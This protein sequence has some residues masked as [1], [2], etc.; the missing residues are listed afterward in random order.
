MKEKKLMLLNYVQRA[1]S[2][3]GLPVSLLKSTTVNGTD[4]SVNRIDRQLIRCK[5]DNWSKTAM[6]CMNRG[7]IVLLLPLVQDPQW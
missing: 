4:A 7:G 2:R 1:S 3:I 6:S 5:T